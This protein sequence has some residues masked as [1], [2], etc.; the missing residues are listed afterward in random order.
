[1]DGKKIIVIY[2]SKTGFTEKYAHWI[3]DDLQCDIVSLEK[4]SIA[5]MAQYDIVIFGGGIYE[6]RI[7][8]IKFVKNNISFLAGKIIIVFA[9]GA[10]APIPEEIKRFEK[11]NIPQGMDITFFYFQSGMN[12]ERVRGADRLL[13]GALKTVLKVKKNK[14]DIERG[15]L[16]AIQNSYDYSSH[17]KIKP[18]CNCINA[19]EL[20]KIKAI[21]PT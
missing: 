20:A 4:F 15:T 12:Y 16:D 13:M 18:L 2:K 7:N 21:L 1:M 6:G 17:S 9:T 14:S 11:D 5:E 8:G 3:V 10:T 19:I